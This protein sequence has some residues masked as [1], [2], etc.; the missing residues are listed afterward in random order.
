MVHRR[1]AYDIV[2]HDFY[3]QHLLQDHLQH[4]KHHYQR[5]YE[6]QEIL[7]DQYCRQWLTNILQTWYQYLQN[8][9]NHKLQLLQL[10]QY[11]TRHMIIWKQWRLIFHERRILQYYQQQ[12]FKILKKY[13]FKHW[14]YYINNLKEQR[15]KVKKIY[16]LIYYQK[17]FKSWYDKVSDNSSPS[18]LFFSYLFPFFLF[19]SIIRKAY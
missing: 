11:K 8:K 1:R 14:N 7:Y 5:R 6:Y 13:H 19:Y 2:Q 3:H 4:W 12:W 16:C 18:F 17:Y 15:N 10:S 9:Y